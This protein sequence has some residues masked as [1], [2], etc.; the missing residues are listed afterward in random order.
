MNTKVFSFRKLLVAFVIVLTGIFLVACKPSDDTEEVFNEVLDTL[1]LVYNGED[2][3][4]SVTQN[5]TLPTSVR[6]VTITWVSSNTAVIT[7]AGVVTR[8]TVDTEV[9]LTATLTLG[10]FEDTKPFT[11]TVLGLADPEDALDAI[12]ITGAELTYDEST[13]RYTTTANL[14]LPTTSLGLTVVWTS[15]NS[16]V[17][18]ANG[19]VVR[20][21]F[22]ESNSTVILTATIA[23]E[24]RTFAVVVL[25][26]TVK[27][28]TQILEEASEV[29]LLAGT[30]N[31]VSLDLEL[32]TQSFGALGEVVTVTWTSSHPDIISATGIVN[33]QPE[34]E[35]V[36]L[37]ATLTYEGQTVTKAFELVVLQFAESHEVQ[38]IAEAQL[39]VQGNT[40]P[41]NPR[42]LYIKIPGVTILGRTNDGFLFADSTGIMFAYTGGAPSSRVVVGEV[43]DVYGIVGFYFGNLQFTGTALN[44]I[45]VTESDAEVTTITPEVHEGEGAVSAILA[46]LQTTEY[47]ASNPFPYRYFEITAKVR[48]QS[49]DNYHTLLVDANY[50]GGDILTAAGTAFTDNAFV[51]YY[52]S[53]RGAFEPFD[54]LVITV[55]VFLYS[56]RTDRNLYTVIFLED[57]ADIETTATDAELVEVVETTVKADIASEY[58]EPTTV[59]LRTSLFGATISYTSSHPDLFNATTGVVTKPEVGQ[60]EVTLTVTVTLNEATKTFTITVFVG[61]LEVIT[62]ADA[63]ALAI[64]RKVRVVAT[65]TALSTNRTFL[66]QDETG[67]ISVYVAAEDVDTWLGYVGKE[68]ELYATRAAHNGLQQLTPTAVAVVGATGGT[69]TPVDITNV[70]L[71][72]EAL[73]PYQSQFVSHEGGLIVKSTNTN[74]DGRVTLVLENANE[75]TIELYWDNRV[76]VANNNI[77]SF[78]VGDVLILNNISLGSSANGPRVHY[79][80]ASQLIKIPS[81]PTSDEDRVQIVA[82][83]LTLPAETDANLTLLTSG[84]F[85]STISW[86][87]N[88]AAINAET[89]AVTL[90]VE[91]V[92]VTLTATVTVGE[93]SVT[94]D[95]VVSVQYN[96]I[97]V[98]A[99]RALAAGQV[100]TVD[101]IVTSVAID[102][103][104]RVVA[105]VQDETAGIYIFRASGDDA[106]KFVVGNRLRIQA[107]TGVFNNLVQLVAPFAA[108]IVLETEVTL[109]APVEPTPDNVATFQG[110]NATVS[111]YLL[112]TATAAQTQY[113][114]VTTEGQFVLYVVGA[115]NSTSAV[116]DAINAKFINVPAGT[117]VTVT[118]GVG[119]FHAVAQIMLFNAEQ[120]TVG[121]AGN[122]E[123]LGPIAADT[124][125]NALPAALLASVDTISLPATGAFGY[126][127][128]W[129]SN[130]AAI[131]VETGAVTHPETGESSVEVTLTVTVKSGET[132]LATETKVVTV[133]PQPFEDTLLYSTGFDSVSPAKTSYADGTTD[134]DGETWRL[135]QSLVGNDPN[136]KKNGTH[137]IRGR[138]VSAAEPGTAELQKDFVNVTRVT[139][140]YANFG[141]LTDG[142]VGLQISKDGGTTWITIWTQAE[143]ASALTAAQVLVN[144]EE[145]DGFTYGDA[146]RFRFIF[147]GTTA[148]QNNSR[149]NL[150]DVSVYGNPVTPE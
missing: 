12:T 20:P 26:L 92:S 77:A 113:I 42:N 131:N 76:A 22:G 143:S 31:G 141:T 130:N 82:G 62:V 51:V 54:G 56:L 137:V 129:T 72:A 79:T 97:T 43:F 14:V 114:I 38:D 116:I 64:G 3:S 96:V 47:S 85:G 115:S 46:G 146:V 8:P 101:V 123:A 105:F 28:V 23:E 37:T 6:G 75:E 87:S 145:L 24:T 135:I 142:K 118:A 108:V 110:Q 125:V 35:T 4:S 32:P 95:F 149:V 103:E 121:T 10:D 11:V 117:Q 40:D 111:G 53:N 148:T 57:I 18:S 136:D 91:P 65:V 139:F 120:I 98:A 150:D 61:E 44:P 16:A 104:G 122:A 7:N 27:P 34:N 67:A 109:P 89:G 68:V 17:I 15:T 48:Y 13:N 1:A 55:R 73:L 99:A 39:W 134:S 84:L 126:T 2:T 58:T 19:T 80:H 41:D 127:L 74:D 71:T 124:A 49:A 5:L 140:N 138:Q 36:V 30:G 81:V 107:N 128:E 88:N 112:E 9:T 52:Q 59:A 83:A 21:G 147:S 100:A 45:A 106:A 133:E 119:Q 70:T 69:F 86:A 50:D 94:K 93:E 66:L 90:S 78:V 60:T 102:G 63:L 144:Y 25:A 132:V 33:R 29:L